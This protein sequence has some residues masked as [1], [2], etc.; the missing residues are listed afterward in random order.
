MIRT[1]RSLA[2]ALAA[3]TLGGIIPARGQDYPSRIIRVIVGPGPD[4]TARLAGAKITEALGQQVVIEPR[5]G[6]GG[7]IAAQAVAGAPPDGYSLLLATASYTINTA[8][9]QSPLD[10]GRDFAPIGL[11]STVPFVLV[12]HPSVPAKSLAE[13]IALAKANPGKLNYA[14]SGI[15]TPPHLAGE[16]FKSMAGVDVVHVPFREANSALNA[17]VS[18]SVEMMFSLASTAAA[19]IDGG[20]VRGIGVTSPKPSPLVPGL[21]AIADEGLTGFSVMGWNGLVA[22]KGTPAPIIDKLSGALQRGLDDAD[23]R[24][25]LVAAGYAPVAR[26]APDDFARFIAADTAKWVEL[27]EKTKMKSQ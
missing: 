21:P 25:R 1:R 27:V 2:V 23:L 24:Q 15:G 7:T 9:A 3:L 22:P 16:L 18:G 19:Q 12:V 6:A 10:L 13:L 20:K 14:S 17:V 26:N 8:M 4:I 5:P 11:I